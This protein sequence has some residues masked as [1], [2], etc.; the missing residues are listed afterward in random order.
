MDVNVAHSSRYDGLVLT[1][2]FDLT[3]EVDSEQPSEGS[4]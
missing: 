3:S 1:S 4:I 2:A